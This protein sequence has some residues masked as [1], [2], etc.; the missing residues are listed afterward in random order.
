MSHSAASNRSQ[1]LARHIASATARPL[2]DA[3]IEKTKHHILDTFAAILSG[4]KME[5]GRQAI[6]YARRQGGRKEAGVL[7]SK[8]RTNVVE[9][10]LANGMSAHAD[11]TDD[12]NP[13]SLTHPGCAVVP[14]AL[15]MAEREGAS[16]LEFLKAVTVGY[17][18]CAR[19]GIALGG[20]NFL[21]SGKD[22]HSF[23]GT[24][25]AVAAA[26]ALA[27]LDADW[28]AVAISY[29]TQQAAGLR[30]LFR[31]RDHTEKAFVF[32]GM[33]AQCGTQAANMVQSGMTGVADPLDTDVSF[34]TAHGAVGDVHKAFSNLGRPFEIMRTNIKRW[35]VGSPAQAVLD[36]LEIAIAKYRIKPDDVKQLRIHLSPRASR[37]VDGREMPD[38]NV[39][40]LA[41]VMLIDG[42]VSFAA[43]H[44]HGRMDDLEINALR[45]RMKLVPDN[46]LGRRS[47]LRQAIVEISLHSGQ[48]VRQRVNA[49][50]GT[51]ANPMPLVEVE[52]KA[53]EL[54]APVIG[55]GP[56]GKVIRGVRR[57]ERARSV[58]ALVAL[59][60]GK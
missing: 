21:N 27:G 44:D 60:Q 12:S 11:E 28:T 41:A 35:S 34:F 14:A 42:T 40:Y 39:Q 37:V 58:E 4:S 24:I 31:D 7:G 6:K 16:G 59:M 46:R 10:A 32:A 47:E 54:M 18:A 5:P 30:T 8:V 20:E 51:T 25:G 9:A 2:P 22:S 49:V 19:T 33:P 52:A 38:V 29:A 3:V 56:A 43:S 17:D 13:F 55:R 53:L 48:Q 50:R 26:G 15:A 57:I 23:G 1:K 36:A 45:R